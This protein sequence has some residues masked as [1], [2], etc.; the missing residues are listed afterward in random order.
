[1]AVDGLVTAELALTGM[2]CAACAGRIERALSHTPS[3]VSAS[4]NFATERAYVAYEPSGTGPDRLCAAVDASGY[5][6]RPLEAAE[7]PA[8]AGDPDHWVLRAL[9]SWPL[10][11]A[12]LAVSLF[13]P[14]TPGAGWTVLLL[15]VAV[16]LAGGWPFLRTSARLLRHGATSMDTLV[17]VGSLAALSV[18]AVEAIALGGRHI[19]LGGAGADAARLHGAMAPLIVA[20]VV[21]G[22]AVEARTRARAADALHALLALRPPMAR[23]VAGPEDEAGRLVPPESVP[24]G[25][26][27]RVRAG[28][29]L[30]LDGVVVAGWS[31]VDESMLTGEPLPVEHGPGHA[32]TGGTRNGGGTLVVRTTT[33]AG[34]SVLAHLQRLVEA[35]QADKPPLQH[36]ADRIS[37]V[38]VPAV[39]AG[40]AVTFLAWWVGA[41]DLGTAVLSAVAVLLVACPCAMG[42]AAPV[43]MMVGT[44]RAATLGV[45]IRS[46]EALER[47]SRVDT[48][49][50]DKT[51]TLTERFARVTA[52]LPAP[53]WD[54]PG[55]LALAA[56]VEVDSDH[57]VASAIR[58]AAGPV[59]PAVGIEEHPGRGVSGRV[60]D[61]AVAVERLDPDRLPADLVGPVAEA[62][63]RGETVV[64]VVVD[65]EVVGAL[66]LTTPVRPEAAAAVAH[67]AAMDLD[68]VVLS[69]DAEPAV[70]AVAATVGIDR[71]ESA[72]LPADKL[73][74]LSGLQSGG[75]RVAMVG[76][77]VNDAPALAA[78]DVGC[79]IGTGS[80]VAVAQSDVALLGADLQGVPAAVGLARHTA[81]VIVQNFG[82]AMGYNLAA[83]PL[84]AAGLLD[85]LVAAVAM[86]LSSIVVVLNSLRLRR[87]GR[88]G[89][90]SV[91]APRTRGRR[92]FVL[93]VLVPVVLFAGAVGVAQAVSPARGQSLLPQLVS[94]TTV[95]LPQ[96]N[97]AQFYLQPGTPGVNGVHLLFSSGRVSGVTAFAQG[98]NGPARALR[99]ERLSPGHYAA[100]TVLGPGRWRFVV[101]A[102][103]PGRPVLFTV[104]RDLH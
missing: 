7:T 83:I 64:A 87:L 103:G 31:A 69:G 11:L 62:A 56:A 43:A 99:L 32:V 35:A 61:R 54:A 79:A 93:S 67:L 28:E 37:A 85:P 18:S 22:R 3:V 36:L 34:E 9:I 94:V 13:G 71:H 20:V 98:P 45:L 19:H 104:E 2:H 96:G 74:A 41:G 102:R 16:E 10:A 60:G 4:V 29:A 63:G 77:G 1:V 6:A 86:G 53:G 23:V 90:A 25:A 40:A 51:G 59:D 15:A 70:A 92:A 50:F 48:V 91:R 21:T 80:E 52:A 46:G 38:F 75:R 57:P 84:A 82:W 17:A 24:V 55:L 12:A 68:T 49:A 95:D 42:L 8:P 47:L 100:Y 58:D 27:V 26:L 88:G 101:R 14:E 65:A 81:S 30:P 73:A 33:V 76:D 39:L 72:L 5:G 97:S 44:G 78:A 89:R 66:C